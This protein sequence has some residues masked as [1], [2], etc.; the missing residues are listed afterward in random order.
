MVIENV[1]YSYLWIE[2]IMLLCLV[3]C[4]FNFVVFSDDEMF[5]FYIGE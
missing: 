2:K 3:G 5:G 1:C 4:Y